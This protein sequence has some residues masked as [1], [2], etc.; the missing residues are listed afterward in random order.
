M[1]KF[2]NPKL[3]S[4]YFNLDAKIL[5][6]AGLIDPFLEIDTQ[7]FIDPVLL[8]KS[9]NSKISVDGY[10]AFRKHFE[11]YLRLL[12][13]SKATDDAAWKAARRLLDL[14]E[15]PQNGLGY[16]GS[17]RSGSSRPEQIQDAILKNE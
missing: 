1:A 8:E 14:R 15:P 2:K 4:T 17:S 7:L 6:E 12:Q 3:F 13:I 16:G 5:K 10:A 11:N 9:S